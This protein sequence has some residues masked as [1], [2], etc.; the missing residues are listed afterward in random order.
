MIFEEGTLG[1]PGTNMDEDAKLW[2]HGL[3]DSELSAR[4]HQVFL[5]EYSLR[6]I[7]AAA[8]WV[9][10]MPSGARR[11]HAIAGMLE[12]GGSEEIQSRQSWIQKIEDAAIRKKANN[13]LQKP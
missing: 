10:S 13:I 12:S 11:D 6:D 4:A 3:P 7:K 5:K 9:E 2:L 8:R 1:A